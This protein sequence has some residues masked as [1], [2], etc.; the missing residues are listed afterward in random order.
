MSLEK[1]FQEA[2]LATEALPTRPTN[3]ELLKLY[4]LY[5]QAMFGDNHEEEHSGF[6]FTAAAKHNLFLMDTM[7]P[8]QKFPVPSA[9]LILSPIPCLIT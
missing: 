1:E 8:D 9:I 5:K 7:D 3:E 4:G 6:D 2:K